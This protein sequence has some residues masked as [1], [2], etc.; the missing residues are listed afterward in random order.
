MRKISPPLQVPLSDVRRRGRSNSW[1]AFPTTYVDQRTPTPRTRSEW[2]E[3]NAV[4][5]S[6]TPLATIFTQTCTRRWR[7]PLWFSFGQWFGSSE[8]FVCVYS[9]TSTYSF[10]AVPHFVEAIEKVTKVKGFPMVLVATQSGDWCFLSW[11]LTW[12]PTVRSPR[13]RG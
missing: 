11:Q 10:D 8:G 12:S 9:V 13:R 4:S 7:F 3:K 1:W 6:W 5:S 2:T